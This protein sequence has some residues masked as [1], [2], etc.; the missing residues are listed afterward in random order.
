MTTRI[1]EG[2]YLTLYI[3][4]KLGVPGAD[5]YDIGA[6]GFNKKLAVV[7]LHS[8]CAQRLRW[9]PIRLLGLA[10]ALASMRQRG[11]ERSEGRQIHLLTPRCGMMGTPLTLTGSAFGPGGG[12][13]RLEFAPEVRQ[14]S[15]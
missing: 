5:A 2:Y 9:A 14:P 1:E 6:I 15:A 4:C 11:I 3:K 13:K 8:V 12:T 7:R 10:F